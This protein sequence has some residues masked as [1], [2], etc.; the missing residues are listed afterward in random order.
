MQYVLFIA[1][2][3]I[4]FFF[5]TTGSLLILSWSFRFSFNYFRKSHNKVP[6]IIWVISRYFLEYPWIPWHC[7]LSTYY[8]SLIGTHY[9][10]VVSSY[11]IYD[12]H[13]LDQQLLI[14]NFQCLSNDCDAVQYTVLKITLNYSNFMFTPL[15]MRNFLLSLFFESRKNSSIAFSESCQSLAFSV[16]FFFLVFWLNFKVRLIYC[17]H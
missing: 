1:Q 2:R 8:L 10:C 16:F 14:A 12:Y 6:E 3:V 4:F 11:L 13:D 15:L 17:Y 9:R 5:C 7:I